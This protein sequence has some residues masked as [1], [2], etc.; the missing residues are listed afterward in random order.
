MRMMR[1][2]N[3]ASQ[4]YRLSTIDSRWS[5]YEFYTARPSPACPSYWDESNCTCCT[6]IRIPEQ[7]KRI[8]GE[9]LA[10]ISANSCLTT[11]IKKGDVFVE[12]FSDVHQ[13]IERNR[14]DCFVL[15]IQRC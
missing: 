13:V 12:R 10:S 11:N 7:Y 9:R 14:T 1:K 5:M 2:L 8:G 4:I 15:L 6:A 3:C